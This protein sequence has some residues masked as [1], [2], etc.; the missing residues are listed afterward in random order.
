MI[1]GISYKPVLNEE[2]KLKVSKNLKDGYEIMQKIDP[3]YAKNISCSDSYRIE[4]WLEIYFSSDM[5]PSEFFQQHKKEPIIKD[6]ELY[7]I[8]VE[9][10]KLRERIRLRTQIMLDS[11]LIDEVF[12]LENKYTRAPNPMKA[13]GIKETLAFFDGELTKSELKERIIINTAQLAKRQR[14]FNTSQFSEHTKAN[15]E[16]LRKIIGLGL[17]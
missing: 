11:G 2:T 1:D 6:L 3:I 5:I 7:E 9:K 15:T 13:I 10:E 17:S 14:T 12:Y 4:K 8:H 16:E